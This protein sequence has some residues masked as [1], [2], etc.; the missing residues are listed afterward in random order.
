MPIGF[1][2]HHLLHEA[3]LSSKYHSAS[4]D[5]QCYLCDPKTPYYIHYHEH[6]PEPDSS[7]QATW[8]N[9]NPF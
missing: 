5:M 6:T 7:I 8:L 9:Y 1:L 2:K 3:L 4:Q